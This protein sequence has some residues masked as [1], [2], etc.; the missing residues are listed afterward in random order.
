MRIPKCP[1]AAFLVVV[2]LVLA[3]STIAQ[4]RTPQPKPPAP[5]P[6]AAPA[7]TFDTLLSIDSY[8]VYVEVR[9]VGQLINSSSFTELLEPVLKLAAPPKEFKTAVKWLTTHADAVTTSRMMVA[10]W[11]TAKNIPNVLVAIELDSAEEAA[12][13]EPQLNEVLQ[14]VLPPQP[15]ATPTPGKS[16]GP[17]AQPTP[18]ATNQT[19]PEPVALTPQHHVTRSGA[20][21]F[22]TSSPLTIKNLKP[23]N[24]KPLNEDQNFRTSY[25]RFTSDTVFAFFNV[26]AIEQE[27]KE[28]REKAIEAQKALESGPYA[29]AKTPEEPDEPEPP[30]PVPSPEAADSVAVTGVIAPAPDSPPNELANL[31]NSFSMA[32]FGGFSEAKWP[33][34]IGLAGNLDATSF[35]VRALFVTSHGEKLPAIPFFPLLVSGPVLVPESPTILPADTELFVTMSLDLPKVYADFLRPRAMVG[36]SVEPTAQAELETP[37]AFIEKKLGAKLTDVLLPLLGDEVVFSMPL[38]PKASPTPTPTATTTAI[39]PSSASDSNSDNFT[40]TQTTVNGTASPT[41]A[42]SVRDKEGLRAFLPKLIEAIGFKGASGFA[43]TQKRED[44]EIVSYGDILSYAFIGNFLVLAP[45]P[46]NINHVVDSY[47]KHET[48]S[49]DI[50][51]KNFTRWQPRQLQGQVYVSP[52]LMESYKKWAAEPSILISDQMREFLTRLSVVSEPV[53]YSL[54]NEGNGPLHQ[55]RVPKNLLLMAVAGMSAETNVSPMTQNERATMGALYMI[56]SAEVTAKKD[57]GAYVTFEDLISQKHVPREMLEGHGYKFYV[58]IGGDGFEAVAVPIEYGTSGKL[59]YFIDQSL[60]IR[61]GDHGGSPATI[62]DKP[63]Q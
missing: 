8:K 7:T 11:P 1:V 63:I 38:S 24:S 47:L 50:N 58:T 4:K 33:E 17:N 19:K 3:P 61:A 15:A 32:F 28:Q 18:A 10:A 20:L 40:L 21:V 62:S 46:K 29:P 41:I 44:V 49:S 2:L 60:V 59:S 53:T 31:L 36:R 54:S 43:K 37:F 22:V 52:A 42:I 25:D 56:A 23:A 55:L 34:A 6:P 51:F 5:K 39:S 35:E 45:D 16:P 13:F 27:E 30:V 57:K 48:L 12:K 9:N 26:K 14:K